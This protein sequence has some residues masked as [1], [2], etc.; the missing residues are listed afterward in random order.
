MRGIYGL[1]GVLMILVAIIGMAASGFGLYFTWNNIPQINA[2]VLSGT[3]L[4]HDT[5]GATDNLLTVVTD[6]LGTAGTSLGAI[7]ITMEDLATTMQTTADATNSVGILVGDDLSNVIEETQASLVSTA[8]SA[9]MIDDFLRLVSAFP[10]LGA[11]Y[12]PAESLNVSIEKIGTSLDPLPKSLVNV[13]VDMTDTSKNLETVKAD[14][15]DL[16]VAI[17]GINTNLEDAKKV[18]TDY[19]VILAQLDD[20]LTGM[21][22]N[23]PNILKMVAYAITGLLVWLLFTQLAMLVQ[24]FELLERAGG[25]KQKV[26]ELIE[27]L[28]EEEKELEEVKEELK[29]EQEELQE[30]SEESEQGK[31]D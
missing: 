3:K 28:E 25:R 12:D 11:K 5:I 6:T 10:L 24:G 13:K 16:N 2:S 29:E 31:P 1:L 30:K 8:E 15:E 23:L 21:E 22:N 18:S 14:I 20:G 7:E 27:K 17:A 19:K 26:D 4:L 9:K